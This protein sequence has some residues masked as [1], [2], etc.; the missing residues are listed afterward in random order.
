M[1]KNIKFIDIFAWMWWTRMWFELA[2]KEF[3][4]KSKCVFTSE[5]KEHA[6]KVYQD[7]FW[8]EK[9]HWDITKINTTEIPDF[10]ILLGGFPCQAFS[11]AWNR[12]WFL[13]TRWTLF[14]EL[15]RIL[16]EKKPYWFLFENVE[17]LINHDKIDKTKPY[18]RTLE[19]IL[20]KLNSLWYNVN[21]KLLNSADFW[22]A[23]N[24]KRIYITWTLKKKI[25]LD[26]FDTYED[27]NIWNILEHGLETIKSDFTK[28]LFNH[29]KPSELLWK[30]IKDKRWGKTNIHSWEIWLKW[31]IS[32]RQ[33]T[34]LNQLLKERRKKQWA[35]QKGIKW[36]DWMPLTLNEIYT[37]FNHIKK[38]ELKKD[39][40]SLV[41]KKYIVLE[42]PKDEVT[43][44]DE[45]GNIHKKRE[46]SINIEKWYNI[47]A[48]KL[49]FPISKILHIDEKAPTIVATDSTKIWVIDNNGIRNLSVIEWKRLFGF[50]DNFIM[51]ISYNKS[52]DLLWNTVVVNV[53]K[54]ISKKIIDD[55]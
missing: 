13:D 14:F 22:I 45:Q 7:N 43:Y 29:F 35:I 44:T 16:K 15:E 19:T 31:E 52:F 51:D 28:K 21:W 23:Q 8:N 27:I 39:L 37:F 17:W 1:K 30:S 24:R 10:D 26:N 50:P 46:Y 42:H 38:S 9:I 41:R 6:K 53:I 33:C 2:C 20:Q 34:L 25:D 40:D 11:S 47:V 18:W 3:W 49:S 12:K 5:I 32:E 55:F 48:G 36:M 54:G 4:L